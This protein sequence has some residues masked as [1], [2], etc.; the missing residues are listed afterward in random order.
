MQPIA[1]SDV[2]AALADVAVAAPVNGMVE[3]AGPEPIGLDALV[4]QLLEARHDERRV[5]TDPS[6]QYFGASLNDQTLTPAAGARLGTTRFADWLVK[7]AV[8]G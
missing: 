3:I 8:P 6:A 4:R 7:N 2:S 1:A 5:I